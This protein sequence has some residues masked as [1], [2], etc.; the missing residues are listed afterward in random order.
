METTPL[1]LCCCVS[2]DHRRPAGAG[3][4]VARGDE[5]RLPFL[6]GSS[7]YAWRNR[8]RRVS[9]FAFIAHADPDDDWKAETTARKANPNYGVSVSP[10][11]LAGKRLKA[12]GMPAAAATY[13]QKHLN[14]WVNVSQPWL[15]VDGWRAGQTEAWMLDALAGDPPPRQPPAPGR[16]DGARGCPDLSGVRHHRPQSVRAV[17]HVRHDALDG[18]LRSVAVG[19]PDDRPQTPRDHPTTL[20]QVHT[21]RPREGICESDSEGDVRVEVMTRASGHGRRPTF[22]AKRFCEA[23]IELLPEFLLV[24]VEATQAGIGI[25]YEGGH[26]SGWIEATPVAKRS[27]RKRRRRT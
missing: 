27:V 26:L 11:D 20:F 6:R 19:E 17:I 7:L 9:R 10:E 3:N 25:V 13:K 12:I 21:E 24:D 5:F 14:L 15:S 18:G 16:V 1:P 22:T 8:R 23:R 2:R 4:K